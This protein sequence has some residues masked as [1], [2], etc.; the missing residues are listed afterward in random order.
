MKVLD[1]GYVELVVVSIVVIVLDVGYVKLVVVST[2]VKVLNVDL[3]RYNIGK[4]CRC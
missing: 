2:V 1:V 4:R 3:H